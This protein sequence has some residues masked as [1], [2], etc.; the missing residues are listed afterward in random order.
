MHALAVI[1]LVGLVVTGM[2]GRITDLALAAGCLVS[3]VVL[4]LLVANLLGVCAGWA[5]F[6]FCALLGGLRIAGAFRED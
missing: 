6:L 5:C 3:G 2:R 4:G 1:L